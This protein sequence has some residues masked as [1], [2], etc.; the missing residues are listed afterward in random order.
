[1]P[2]KVIETE[3]PNVEPV[4]RTRMDINKELM[5]L[6]P[7]AG[8]VLGVAVKCNE[9][10]EPEVEVLSEEDK[11]TER[12][13]R[14][15]LLDNVIPPSLSDIHPN[16]VRDRASMVKKLNR[17][18]LRDMKSI[19]SEAVPTDGVLAEEESAE[20]QTRYKNVSP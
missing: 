11:A 1:M 14:R 7:E 9:E 3:S 5:A 6:T 10:T 13:L 8:M 12:R 15:F 16:P 2:F 17:M 4:A 19:W 20:L 18:T